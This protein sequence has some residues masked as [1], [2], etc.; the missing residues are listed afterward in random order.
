MD[1]CKLK[2]QAPGRSAVLALEEDNGPVSRQT[3]QTLNFKPVPI[4]PG[5]H[6]HLKGII[7]SNCCIHMVVPPDYGPRYARNM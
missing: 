6:S 2:G 1:T 5:Q 3:Q 4:Q 7:G